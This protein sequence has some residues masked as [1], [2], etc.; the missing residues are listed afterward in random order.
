MERRDFMTSV[1]GGAL[2]GAVGT[3]AVEAAAAHRPADA[4]FHLNYAPHFGMF[5]HSAG[6]DPVAQLEFMAERGFGALE[7]NGM[8]GRSVA[9]QERIARAMARLGMTM[10]VFVAYASFD[11]PTFTSG[12]EAKH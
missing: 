1:A 2:A 10:G 12:T 7:D 8:R 9:E 5:R 6:D 3:T 4:R 11:E